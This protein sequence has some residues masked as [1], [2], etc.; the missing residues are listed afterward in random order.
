M[1]L[2]EEVLELISDTLDVEVEELIE[3]KKLYDSIGVDSTET[4]ELVVKLGKR[5]G[6]K[7]ETDEITKFS[8]PLEIIELINKKK[9]G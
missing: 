9:Q 8:T 6:V 1:G 4:V 7:I 2:K 5:F 3:D